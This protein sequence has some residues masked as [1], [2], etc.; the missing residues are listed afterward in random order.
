MRH[1]WIIQVPGCDDCTGRGRDTN[2][3]SVVVVARLGASV[4]KVSIDYVSNL[5]Q[6]PMF[7]RYL[8]RIPDGWAEKSQEKKSGQAN[9]IC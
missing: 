8:E 4:S 1:E 2:L 5:Y 7:E 9:G 6:K 3:V